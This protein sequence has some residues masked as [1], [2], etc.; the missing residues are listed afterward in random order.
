MLQQFLPVYLDV[1]LREEYADYLGEV[2][3]EGHTDSD[4]T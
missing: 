1:L 2:I 4:G 3:I